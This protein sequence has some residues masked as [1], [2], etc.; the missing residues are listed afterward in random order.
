MKRIKSAIAKGATI[1]IYEKDKYGRTVLD[2]TT[3][4]IAKLLKQEFGQEKTKE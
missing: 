4:E 3:P 2:K 1:D